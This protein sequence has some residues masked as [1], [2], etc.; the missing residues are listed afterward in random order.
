MA[1]PISYTSSPLK[2][3]ESNGLRRDGSSYESSSHLSS[4]E[5]GE[6]AVL[7]RDAAR[8]IGR[9]LTI[10]ENP[11]SVMIVAKTQE[12][13]LVLF[14]REL[15][16][17]LLDTPRYVDE[18]F[19]NHPS[20][21]YDHLV[22]KFP[23]YKTRLLFW[24][25][26]FCASSPD[27]IDFIITLGGD[28]TV[29]YA[30]WLF[31]NSQVPPLL[32]FHFGSLGFLTVFKINDITNVLNRVVGCDR[33]AIRL[34][35]RMRLSCTV[36]KNKHPAAPV[37]NV[38]LDLQKGLQHFDL[39][40]EDADK[41]G[42][43]ASTPTE[44]SSS[45]L[46]RR[47]T[48]S[49][50]VASRFNTLPQHQKSAFVETRSHAL[51]PE[52]AK[53]FKVGRFEVLN[54]IVIDRGP[55]AYMSQL[56]LFVEDRHLTTVQADG[57]VIST[58]TGSTAYSLA[59][60][61]SLVHPEVPSFLL[62]PICAHSLSFRPMLLPDSIELKIQVPIDSRNN[63][64]VSFDGR[65]RMEL[66]QGDFIVVK[67]SRFPMPSVCDEDQSVDW[68]ASLKKSLHWNERARQRAFNPDSSN[69]VADEIEDQPMN[70]EQ[71]A[72]RLFESHAI[73]PNL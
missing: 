14:T 55:S 12:P 26:E 47:I 16:R 53:A 24:T 41:A 62:T 40:E 10:F 38:T 37:D 58:P 21:S 71:L 4:V 68:F 65:H 72:T 56:E 48:D 1:S 46:S 9:T 69:G 13:G 39:N 35:M 28:G 30:T 19:R 27:L 54:D 18:K 49:V 33:T 36:W 43:T 67:L 61:G 51:P 29:L 60:G 73:T 11:R 2:S 25:P 17:N 20:F 7:I 5:L 66:L 52:N 6:N 64:W 42:L 32:P 15:T 50:S 44:R 70:L 63:A 3:S 34:N 8:G 31:Q 57:L 59:A 23:S 45:L 22:D